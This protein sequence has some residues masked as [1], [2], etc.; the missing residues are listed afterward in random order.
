MRLFNNASVWDAENQ[1]WIE[2]FSIDNKEVDEE[3][4]FEQ[5]E[6]EEYI[7]VDECCECEICCCEEE[8][9]DED[10]AIINLI[11][12]YATE[13]E[14]GCECGCALRNILMDSFLT[15]RSIGSEEMKDSM[16]EF[17]G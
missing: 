15:G 10:K 17:L 9:S 6:A 2:S 4:Y 3:V 5:I 14:N 8:F 1:K 11:E 7:I 13:V 12:E 16:R